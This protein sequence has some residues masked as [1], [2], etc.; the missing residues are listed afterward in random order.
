MNTIPLN[1]T[2][3][4]KNYFIIIL[5]LSMFCFQSQSVSAS[6]SNQTLSYKLDDKAVDDLFES[7]ND[8]T[9]TSTLGN[10]VLP[11][12]QQA[13]NEDK[14]MIAGIVALGSWLLGVGVLIPIHRLILGTGN[15]AGKIIALYCVTLSGC[16]FILLIDGIMLLMDSDGNKYVENSK[17]IMWQ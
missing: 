2:K 14:Q 17:F 6:E 10:L 4:M 13:Q 15:Q 11:S 5:V 8:I 3:N 7:S 12:L 1:Q 16:G 9:F